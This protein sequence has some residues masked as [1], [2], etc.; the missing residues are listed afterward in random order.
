IAEIDLPQPNSDEVLVRVHACALNRADLSMLTGAMHGKHG[1]NGAVLGLEWAGEVAAVGASVTEF[2]PGDKVMCSGKGGFAEYALT[3]RGRVMPIPRS[4]MEYEQAACFPVALQTMHDAIVTQ[5]MLQPGQ[6]VLI[7]GAST[8]VGLMGIQIAKHLGAGLVIG[9]STT[10]AKRVQL[11]Q[12]GLDAAVD[13]S[14]AS[15]LDQVL[16]LTGSQGADIV[17]DQLAGRYANQNLRATKVGG[18][19]VN[20]GRLAGTE[21]LFDFNLHA[22]RRISFI[23]VTFRTRSIEDVREIKR[24]M[25][26]DLWPALAAGRLQQPIDRCYDFDD[27]GTGFARMRQNAHF[28]KIVLRL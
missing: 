18:R 23:G 1:G 22:L 6:T 16:L 10:P 14:V 3:D 20:V 28:G 21:D 19:I 17:I 24:R 27:V 4:D 7:Q 11:A 2:R 8:G 15:W 9:T 12:F 25:M 26:A 5:G 13:S